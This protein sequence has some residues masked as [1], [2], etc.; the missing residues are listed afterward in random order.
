MQALRATEADSTSVPG[1]ATT[2]L[3]AREGSADVSQT[4]VLETG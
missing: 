3:V 2:S 4:S 1:V